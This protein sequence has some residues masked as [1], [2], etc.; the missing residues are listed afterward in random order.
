MQLPPPVRWAQ[1]ATE[2]SAGMC[3]VGDA[4]ACAGADDDGVGGRV[5]GGNPIGW[6][7]TVTVT[8]VLVGVT[9]YQ[10]GILQSLRERLQSRPARPLDE[11]CQ[12]QEETCFE[13]CSESALP[14]PD[15]GFKFFNCMNR[16][17]AEV[18]CL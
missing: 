7:I 18:G 10:S 11:R 6:T 14:T 9:V 5:L 1:D 4:G 16:C 13:R 12:K 8:V 17:M 15:H 3:E 2:S